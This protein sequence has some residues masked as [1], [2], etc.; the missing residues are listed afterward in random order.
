MLNFALD[1]MTVVVRLATSERRFGG[2]FFVH[3]V[4]VESKCR[5]V[6]QLVSTNALTEPRIQPLASPV[7]PPSPS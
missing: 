2:V 7:G 6:W 3:N 5:L 1:A 4:R